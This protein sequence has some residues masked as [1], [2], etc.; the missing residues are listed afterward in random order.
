MQNDL[1]PSEIARASLQRKTA[2]RDYRV[3]REQELAL[4]QPT[5]VGGYD[6]DRSDG[7]ILTGGNGSQYGRSITNGGMGLG[8]RISKFGEMV[9]AMPHIKRTLRQPLAPSAQSPYRI[10]YLILIETSEGKSIYAGGWQKDLVLVRFLPPD[11]NI[12][13][14][15]IDN[16]GE[17]LWRVNLG[18]LQSGDQK[19]IEIISPSGVVT[20]AVPNIGTQ[21]KR[22]RTFPVCAGHGFWYLEEYAAVT[23]TV[24]VP[25]GDVILELGQSVTFT[26]TTTLV[27]VNRF[28][29]SNGVAYNSSA[30]LEFSGV[31]VNTV[32]REPIGGGTQPV[33]GDSEEV[34]LN[35]VPRLPSLIVEDSRVETSGF[36]R[37]QVE[38]SEP[39]TI[40]R[41]EQTLFYNTIK[42]SAQGA[43]GVGTVYS[44][45]YSFDQSELD[46][47]PPVTST[48]SPVW[49]TTAGGGSVIPS[50]N[51]FAFS[52]NYI[53]VFSVKLTAINKALFLSLLSAASNVFT[54][55]VNS[56]N[57]DFAPVGS[58]EFE[59]YKSTLNGTDPVSFEVLSA[60]FIDF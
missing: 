27:S 3:Q 22:I 52:S 35:R 28:Q 5:W 4:P 11:S 50:T 10:K 14:A 49:Y 13:H 7:V 46:P 51:T 55:P 43:N 33:S 37:P 57:T 9:T 8:Q 23:N 54:V 32:W 44:V 19:T 1:D 24:Q 34:Y 45:D 36:S 17:D 47:I 20:Y 60:S 12:I 26:T 39:G 40:R 2:D 25:P 30:D 42:I 41:S 21:L 56:F 31:S 6:S 38:P 29:I 53:D 59:V 15:S 16:L 48:T 18:I 58:R